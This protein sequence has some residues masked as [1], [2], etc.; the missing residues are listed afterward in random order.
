MTIKISKAFMDAAIG[1]ATE[2]IP[3]LP[4]PPIHHA[5]SIVFFIWRVF[6]GVVR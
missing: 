5:H 6:L 1:F 2:Q 4:R 3:R